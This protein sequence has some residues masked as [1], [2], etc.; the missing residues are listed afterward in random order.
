MGLMMSRPTSKYL[1][2][3]PGVGPV[4][5]P[6]MVVGEAPGRNE[7]ENGVPFCGA[8]GRLLDGAFA[9][10]GRS[11]DE[12]YITNAFKGDVGAGNRNPTQEELDD[13]WPLLE[14]EI[15][16]VRPR[17]ILLLGRVAT[18]AFMP[19]ISVMGSV[20]GQVFRSHGANVYPCWHPAYI[21]RMGRRKQAEFEAHIANFIKGCYG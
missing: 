12:F 3:V 5:A 6:G 16:G 21:L 7:I 15:V 1:V 2:I 9:A 17:G 14:A 19:G 18:E 8:S 20:V 13:H 4:P 11:R 10:C